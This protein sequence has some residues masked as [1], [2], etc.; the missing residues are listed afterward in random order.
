MLHTRAAFGATTA[1]L[2]ASVAT[3]TD[4]NI[5]ERAIA[6]LHVPGEPDFMVADGDAVWINVWGAVRKFRQTS[7]KPIVSVV[8][9][10]PCAVPVVAFGD[11]WTADCKKRAL[12]RV[13]R[14]TGAI[15]AVIRTGLSDP[16]GELIVTSGAGS[17]WITT[18]ASGVLSRIDPRNNEIVAKIKVAPKSY[19]AVYGF[20]AV[21]VSTASEPGLLQRI[22]PATNSVT[23]TITVGPQPRFFAI[24]EGSIWTLNHGD[25]TVSRVDP[26]THHVVATID[27]KGP[28][29]G[30]DIDVG[31]GRV[32]ARG[33]KI[34]LAVID[35]HSN[36]IT[37]RYY[38]PPS[39]A[40]S[41][42]KG[43]SV[44]VAKD[45]VWVGAY[46]ISTVW[47]LPLN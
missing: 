30:G 20:D 33:E 1:L 25:G 9:P 22:D 36:E 3:A 10:E 11:L 26:N 6:T 28:H 37:T 43:A 4:I 12:Y 38:L 24:G 19:S 15:K 32:W 21:W 29:K 40:A 27:V 14:E 18:D 13:D 39:I 2:I 16:E 8:T 34:P 47:V 45:G 31:A 35:P 23:D 5:A 17:I 7:D 42:P 44:R 46:K 41:V